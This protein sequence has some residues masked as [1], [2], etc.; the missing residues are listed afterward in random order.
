LE[1]AIRERER[2]APRI[3]GMRDEFESRLMA[4]ED[5][6][7][8]NG[9]GAP[10]LPNTSNFSLPGAD[11][12][13]VLRLAPEIAASTGSACGNLDPAPSHVLRAMGRS[14]EA[15][16]NA[17]RVSFGRFSRRTDPAAAAAALGWAFEAARSAR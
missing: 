9:S 6:L 8:I 3:A 11:A 5:G 12:E 2:E 4:T 17:I 1:Y 13:E 14:E 16:A 7:V 15:A 10:R